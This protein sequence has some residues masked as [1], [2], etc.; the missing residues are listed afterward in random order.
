MGSCLV[1]EYSSIFTQLWWVFPFQK[2]INQWLGVAP[3]FFFFSRWW[4]LF[5]GGDS[6]IR[7]DSPP[8]CRALAVRWRG[9]PL[10]SR[11]PKCQRSTRG[12]YH[13]QNGRCLAKRGELRDRD[14]GRQHIRQEG[15]GSIVTP[16]PIYGKCPFLKDG[17]F[18]GDEILLNTITKVRSTSAIG[19]K[20]FFLSPFDGKPQRFRDRSLLEHKPFGQWNLE[21]CPHGL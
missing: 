1:Y 16:L 15:E 9:I 8:R 18:Q 17:I 21:D 7:F 2:K 3:M 6:S 20:M 14:G 19:W 12:F 11:L 4:T 5:P 10:A 13:C